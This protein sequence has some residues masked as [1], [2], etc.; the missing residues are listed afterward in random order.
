MTVT[1]RL[2]VL[3][4]TPIHC[5][6]TSITAPSF[7]VELAIECDRLGY[8]RYWVAEHHNSNQFAGTAPEILLTRIAS[9]TQRMRVGSGGVMLSHYSPYK[10]AETFSLLG[11]LFPGRIDLGIGRAP[12]GNQ[13]SAAALA[14]PGSLPQRDVFPQQAA[15]LCAFIRGDF[16]RNH[17]YSALRCA[18]DSTTMPSLWMLGS[19]GGSS[20]LAGHLGM[21]L[22]LARFI[23][24]KVCS[25]T[26]FSQ[27]S[28]VYGQSGYSGSAP[29]LL[30]LAV[31]CASSDAEARF[32]AGTA[33]YRKMM[34]GSPK[35]EPLL[36]PAEVKMRYAS[37]SASDRLEFDSTLEDMVVGSPETCLTKIKQLSKA[38]DCDEIAILTVTYTNEDRL[39]SYQLLAKVFQLHEDSPR[40]NALPSQFDKA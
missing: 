31:I 5:G 35:R 36:S 2:T 19:G 7:S 37:M 17:P 33:V 10:V 9:A 1:L 6:F 30:A 32:I 21:G 18:N 38:F 39:K 29:H 14:A 15:E 27:H 13:L 23:A 20:E 4:Q 11:G 16:P 40:I 26:I 24:P 34:A 8:H 12:G 25:P 28:S 22:A 3:D